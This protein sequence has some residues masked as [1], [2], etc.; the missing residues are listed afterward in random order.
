MRDIKFRAWDKKSDTMAKWK[1]VQ[2]WVY[3]IPWD[4][5]F[6]G[7]DLVLMQYTGLKDKNG[8]ERCDDDIIRRNTGY[9]FIEKKKWFSL[10][11]DGG[12]LAYGYDYHPDDEVIGNIHEHK[13]LLDN[14]EAN[15][16][17]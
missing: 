1:M 3:A 7:D 16:G 10:G 11:V 13:H 2:D 9:T 6:C 5:I 8:K 17:T 12:V 4:V 14:Q 15:D